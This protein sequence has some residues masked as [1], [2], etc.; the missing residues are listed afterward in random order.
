MKKFVSILLLSLTLI[1]CDKN[2]SADQNKVEVVK[3]VKLKELKKQTIKNVKNYNGDLK[4]LNE[5]SII[6]PTGGYV[7]NINFKNGDN[8][9]NQNVILNLTDASTEA[10]FFESEGNLIKA[11]SN[12]NTSKTSF[13]KYETLYK[14]KLISEEIYLEYKNKL[15]QSFGDLKIAESNFIRA[16]DN[17]KRLK[18]IANIPGII[19]DLNLK[20][21]EK[22]SASEKILT[23]IDNSSMEIKISIA[24]EDIK[25]IFIGKEAKIYVP[26]LNETF[27]GTISEINLSADTD[28]KK[29]SVK[30]IIPNTNQTILKGMY[31]KVSIEQ[32]NIEGIFVPKESIMIKD[33]YSYVAIIRN[34]KAIIYKVDRGI[35]QNDLQEIKFTDY[36]SGDQIVI[37]G[38]YLLNNNDKVRAI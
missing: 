26:D 34:N 10:S 20:N 5:V 33:L 14:K 30:I 38:Q 4:P 23:I 15:Q 25:N 16:N 6:T 27:I 1:G 3:D 13:D 35:S 2:D 29:Y 36:K 32:G 28:T 8:V 21:L 18:V 19:S 7:K 31:G 17:Y 22:V 11:K 37:Q 12:Y 24:G 9:Y